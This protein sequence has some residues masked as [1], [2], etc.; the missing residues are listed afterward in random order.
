MTVPKKGQDAR[1]HMLQVNARQKAFYESR[2]DAF[3][4]GTPHHERAANVSTNLWSRMRRRL[5]GM[6]QA[7]SV[8]SYLLALHQ[9]WLAAV[10]PGARVLDLGC[11]SGNPLSFWIAERCADYTGIDLSEQAIAQLNAQLV[12]SLF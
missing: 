4:A 5:I 2:F 11:F 1:S 8:D 3:Q 7:S 10:L 9:E 6:R 12:L